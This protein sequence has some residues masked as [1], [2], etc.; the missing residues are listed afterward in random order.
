M[1]VGASLAP[2]PHRRR[3]DVG[4]ELLQ[5]FLR[6]HEQV[7]AAVAGELAGPAV[8]R[9]LDAATGR[10]VGPAPSALVVVT[11]ARVF[12]VRRHPGGRLDRMVWD[13]GRVDVDAV[14][15]IRDFVVIGTGASCVVFRPHH[16][17]GVE[18]LVA[19]M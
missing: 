2:R 5:R 3:V 18:H 13:C 12:A 4:P 17:G 11:S 15:A 1:L 9:A 7:I 14:T 16:R 19:A 8:G 6:D 10:V